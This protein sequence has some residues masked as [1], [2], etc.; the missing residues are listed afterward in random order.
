MSIILLL[1]RRKPKTLLL[2]LLQLKAPARKERRKCHKN[3][4]CLAAKSSKQFTFFAVG[5]SGG[6]SEQMDFD[7]SPLVHSGLVFCNEW[8]HTQ[9]AFRETT[10]K[11][12][13]KL[14]KELTPVLSSSLI[15]NSLFLTTFKFCLK[16]YSAAFFCKLANLFSCLVTFFKEGLTLERDRK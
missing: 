11:A 2:L 7:F 4:W 1:L 12:K 10:Q 3:G 14:S 5:D 9:K 8:H 15:V 6:A 16:L 13:K